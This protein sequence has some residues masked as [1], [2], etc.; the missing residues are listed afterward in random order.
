MNRLFRG[1]NE[2]KM[3]SSILTRRG[4]TDAN[5]PE[6]SRKAI[7]R[8]WHVGILPPRLLEKIWKYPKDTSKTYRKV[9]WNRW[10]SN[11]MDCELVHEE[12]HLA[13][14]LFQGFP[15]LKI[16]GGGVSPTGKSQWSLHACDPVAGVE[17]GNSPPRA[18]ARARAR[19]SPW[20]RRCKKFLKWIEKW[21]YELLEHHWCFLNGFWRLLL[22]P[23]KVL[24]F[25]FSGCSDSQRLSPRS[26]WSP[27]VL[28]TPAKHMVSSES[29]WI[30]LSTSESK[31]ILVSSHES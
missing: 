14:D 7:L 2:L 30:H 13:A 31:W 8:D 6:S 24:L 4:G 10:V 22:V 11:E 29:K 20:V 21:F 15:G 9:A 1:A 26:G 19:A 23:G 17:T 28:K 27:L 16:G 18:R 12:Q 3:C 5:T 25:F